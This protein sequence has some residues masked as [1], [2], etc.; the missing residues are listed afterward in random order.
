VVFPL[1]ASVA[2]VSLTP[3][4]KSV[5]T[6]AIVVPDIFHPSPV[7]NKYNFE[8]LTDFTSFN[9]VAIISLITAAG[10]AIDTLRG[11]SAFNLTIPFTSKVSLSPKLLS[12]STLADF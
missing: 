4:G 7:I 1:A 8:Y 5:P 9:P 11:R 2:G 10:Q 12:F 6:L 3:V